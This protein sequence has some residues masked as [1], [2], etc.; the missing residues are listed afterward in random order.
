LAARVESPRGFAWWHRW[1]NDF[2][3]E[4]QLVGREPKSEL[5]LRVADRNPRARAELQNGL[6]PCASLS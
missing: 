5:V 4:I 3:R 6:G 2:V 1:L